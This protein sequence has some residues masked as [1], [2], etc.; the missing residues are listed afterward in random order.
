MTM[1]E[2]RKVIRNLA[3][4]NRFKGLDVSIHCRIDASC[5]MAE[6]LVEDVFVMAGNFWDFH[7][8]CHGGWFYELDKQFGG[9]T[10]PKGLTACLQRALLAAGAKTVNVE[11]GTYRYD[12]H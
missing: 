2:E 12:C 7:P 6:V 9:F 11:Q 4:L 5:E 1:A 8:G 3:A 10:S